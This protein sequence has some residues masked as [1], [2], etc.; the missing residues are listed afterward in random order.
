LHGMGKR[1]EGFH[2]KDLYAGG[3]SSW[4]R[5]EMAKHRR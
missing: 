1:L 5:V 2:Q 4:W 3:A